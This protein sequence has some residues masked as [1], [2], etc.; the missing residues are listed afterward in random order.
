MSIR[1]GN[2]VGFV[3]QGAIARPALVAAVLPQPEGE[4]QLDLV[5]ATPRTLR[6]TRLEDV[7]MLVPAVPPCGDRLGPPDGA[8]CGW[9]YAGPE[10]MVRPPVPAHSLEVKP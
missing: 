1:P 6:G 9:K 2:V 4:P 8:R 3:V 7:A 5:I 10:V